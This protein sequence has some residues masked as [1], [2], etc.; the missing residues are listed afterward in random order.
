MV[1]KLLQSPVCPVKKVA[2]AG[3][4]GLGLLSLAATGCASTG[5]AMG[6]KPNM[7]TAHAQ[8]MP[9]HDGQIADATRKD[10]WAR[11]ETHVRMELYMGSVPAEHLPDHR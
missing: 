4:I 7:H 10:G 3:I 5:S 8:Q 1:K 9:E 6:N 2:M 11:E